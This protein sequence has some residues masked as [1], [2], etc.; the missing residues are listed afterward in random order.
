MNGGT[1]QTFWVG[2]E[3]RWRWAGYPNGF[4]LGSG[5]QT[6]TLKGLSGVNPSRGKFDQILMTGSASPSPFRAARRKLLEISESCNWRLL[7]PG[8]KSAFLRQGYGDR[9]D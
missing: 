7:R 6:V 9:T 2:G 4:L 1:N 8:R 5:V 3:S